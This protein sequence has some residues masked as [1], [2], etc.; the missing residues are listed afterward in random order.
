VTRAL[1]F[2]FALTPTVRF[3][4]SATQ[5]IIAAEVDIIEVKSV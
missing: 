1:A 5:L 2:A 4:K 3:C